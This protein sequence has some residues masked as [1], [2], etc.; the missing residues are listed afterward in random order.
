M[1]ASIA[2]IFMTFSESRLRY[3]SLFGWATG[4]LLE[5]IA[6][7]T[8]RFDDAMLIPNPSP[9][10]YLFVMIVIPSSTVMFIIQIRLY[11]FS[12]EKINQVIPVGA[13]GVELELAHYRKK[14]FK[15]AF[16]AGI[17]ALAFYVC[18]IPLTVVLLYELL[19]GRYISSPTRPICIGLSFWNSSADPLIYGFG[20]ADTRKMILRYLKRMKQYLYN[21]L[22]A[23]GCLYS[24]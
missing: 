3:G 8:C 4:L 19:S 23:N 10:H 12:R 9:L 6:T 14:K 21:I 22:P 13:Y 15:V 18:V 2:S 11:L 1:H 5:I 7:I 16:M 20:M 24:K 17:V